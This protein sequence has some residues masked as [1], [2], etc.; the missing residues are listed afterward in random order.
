MPPRRRWLL[1]A[2]ALVLVAWGSI[3]V[4][5][6]YNSLERPEWADTDFAA[7]EEVQLLQEYIAVD[8]TSGKE[9]A[10]AEWLAAKLREHGIEP[11]VETLAPG[12]ANLWAVI[13]GKRPEALVL[14]HHIDVYPVNEENWDTPPFEGRIL[15]PFLA[16]RGSFDMKS[17]GVAQLLAFL[18]VAASG[19]KPEYSLILLATADEETG[20]RLGA[21][22]FIREHPELVDRF[23]TV[24]TEGGAN[25]SFEEGAVRYWGVEVG[26]AQL[27][28]ITACAP[29]Q[30]R[31]EELALDL[32]RLPREDVV[33]LPAVAKTLRALTPHRRSPGHVLAME[34]PDRLPRDRWRVDKL[35]EFLRYL[36]FDRL[37][38][39]GFSN[40]ETGAKLHMGVWRPPGRG[41]IADRSTLD[42]LLPP[43]LTAGVRFS[44][45]IDPGP[46]PS[47]SDHPVFETLTRRLASRGGD[48]GPYVLAATLTDSRDFRSLGIP[49]YGYS[50]F[51]FVAAGLGGK[52]RDNERILLTSYVDGVEE[53][54]A[55]VAEIVGLADRNS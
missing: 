39:W 24:L 28:E 30:R 19:E 53:Y 44:I 34:E 41:P 23:W 10:G 52:D 51:A 25:E 47:P 33:V 22:W 43:K 31:L 46:E 13:E 54:R 18:D 12:Q 20:S 48:A 14:H 16:G 21:R 7:M 26:H 42:G 35:P 29:T 50:P 36:T 3:K 11:H 40:D 8:T 9:A 15:G 17:Y 38:V 37:E 49:S 1:I 55:A 5:Q 2:F 6:H 4:W 32:L 27:I 45:Q